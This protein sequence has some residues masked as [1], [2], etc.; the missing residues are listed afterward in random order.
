[1]DER[2]RRVLGAL[3]R[4]SYYVRD[5]WHVHD[6]DNNDDNNDDN[7]DNI[8]TVPG[9]WSAWEKQ[10]NLLCEKVKACP[11]AVE[12]VNALYQTNT[13]TKTTTP[14]NSSCQRLKLAIA[15]S[16]R[17]EQVNK[18]ATRHRDS[19]FDKISVIVAGDNPNVKHGKPAPDIFLEA[20]RQLNDNDDDDD[21]NSNSN[22]NTIIAPSECIV[23]EDTRKE[24]RVQ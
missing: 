14:N 23:F 9:I 6:D 2:D 17:M 18:K 4:A 24:Y 16:S 15:T 10:C 5:Y 19:I 3:F 12:L 21:D 13:N 8:M 20:V 22:S 1:M 11:G 7:D